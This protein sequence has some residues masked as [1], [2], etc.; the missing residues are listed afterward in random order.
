LCWN[1][2]RPEWEARFQ[3]LEGNMR[4]P[5]PLALSVLAIG[6]MGLAAVAQSRSLHYVASGSME[7]TFEVCNRLL[8]TKHPYARAS[9]V[10]RG[11]VVVFSYTDPVRRRGSGSFIGRVVGL[12]GERIELKGTSVLINGRALRHERAGSTKPIHD[13]HL[14]AKT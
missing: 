12:P 4:K 7:P 6:T 2:P 9:D 8:T 1:R 14:P 10:R 11:D 5:K 3:P 13:F